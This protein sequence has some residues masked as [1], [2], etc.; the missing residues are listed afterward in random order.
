MRGR[1]ENSVNIKVR[2]MFV[3]DVNNGGMTRKMGVNAMSVNEDAGRFAGNSEVHFD[4]LECRNSH[5][6]T[7]F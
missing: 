7:G 4:F 5:G 1:G 2:L 3:F 6:G